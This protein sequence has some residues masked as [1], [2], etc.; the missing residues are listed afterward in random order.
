MLKTL[1]ADRFKLRVHA[2]TR[3][4]PAYRL[5]TTKN[6][7]KLA[8]SVT[9]APGAGYTLDG[10]SVVFHSTS[11]SAFADYLSGRGPI[12]RPVVDG[13]GQQMHG[14]RLP[15]TRH[16]KRTTLVRCQIFGA[17]R[18]PLRVEASRAAKIFQPR[19]ASILA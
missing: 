8:R 10:G 7:P 4:L 2:E 15:V 19:H 11:I 13:V 16:D 14:H 9:D 12:D 1:L 18:N 17:F 3:Q 5:I 6:G